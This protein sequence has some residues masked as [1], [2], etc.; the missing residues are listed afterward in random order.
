MGRKSSREAISV[1][2]AYLLRLDAP[3]PMHPE[4]AMPAEPHLLSFLA[5][6]ILVPLVARCGGT[7]SLTEER[8]MVALGSDSVAVVTHAANRPG[9]T[10]INVHD[11]ENTSVQAGLDVIRRPGGRV[12]ELQHMDRRNI[13]FTLDGTTYEFD[14]NRMFTDVGAEASLH[15]FGAYSD[16]AFAVVRRFADELIEAY[17]LAALSVVV[18]L[19]NNTEGTY[20]AKSYAEGGEYEEDAADVF[21]VEGSDPDDF[22]FVTDRGIFEKLKAGG[23]NVVLQDNDRATDDGSLSVFC[24]QHDI[25][26][27]NV[28]AQRGHLEAQI[29]MLDY[30]AGLL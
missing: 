19:H 2:A 21:I 13:V 4:A 27:V 9:L 29:R 23:F 11:D 22:F 14:P 10:Y 8:R 18:T 17:D 20:S 7:P 24:G 12:I 1:A 15:R 6:L 5:V 28:E 30:L 16:S 3:S 25:P 26:Y